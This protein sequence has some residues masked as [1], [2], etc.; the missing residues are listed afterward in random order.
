MLAAAGRRRSSSRVARRRCTSTARRAID[1]GI[2]DLGVP[3][4]RHLLRRAAGRARPRRRGRRD[5]RGRVR[6]HRADRRRSG[7]AVRATPTSSTVWMSHFDAITAAPTGSVVTATPRHPGRSVRRPEPRHLRRAVPPRG[8][9]HPTRPGDHGGFLYD[10]RGLPAHVDDVS[11][12]EHAVAAIRAQVGYG[13]RH[14]RAVGRGRLRRRGRARAQGGRSPAHV[15]VR[16]HRPACGRARAMLGR[17]VTRA[18]RTPRRPLRRRRHGRRDAEVDEPHLPL[19]VDHHVARR[20]VAMD[21]VHAAMR[22][23]ERAADL[24]ADVRA[25]FGRE[26]R[27]FVARRRSARARARRRSRPSTSSIARKY[28]PGST[29]SS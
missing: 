14:L 24:D 9:A 19:F 26:R 10:A 5:G 27:R 11:I 22:V 21:D 2:Y 12:I 13:P 20:D 6:P 1:P 25:F 4:A 18:S 23:V 29:P 8:R 15:R 7:R 3:A 28:M 16:R 17:H